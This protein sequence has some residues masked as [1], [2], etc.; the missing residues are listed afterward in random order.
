MIILILVIIMII[1]I[2]IFSLSRYLVDVLSIFFSISHLYFFPDI[3]KMDFYDIQTSWT[4][5]VCMGVMLRHPW[6]NLYVWVDKYISVSC[7]WCLK[8]L[9]KTF[10]LNGKNILHV[11]V[12]FYSKT[13]M[14]FLL[15][16]TNIMLFILNQ[17]AYTWTIRKK[18]FWAISY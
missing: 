8:F 18:Q 4:K 13:P 14:I 2:E 6:Q 9:K 5:P 3:L 12:S 16:V 10:C 17:N 7:L 15:Q 1:I 11:C